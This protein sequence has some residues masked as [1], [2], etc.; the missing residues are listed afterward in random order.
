MPCCVMLCCEECTSVAGHFSQ[1]NIT[2]FA[3]KHRMHIRSR[4]GRGRGF[5]LTRVVTCIDI[6]VSDPSKTLQY[7]NNSPVGIATCYGLEGPGIEFRCGR[8]FPRPSRP[9]VVSTQPPTQWVPGLSR[10]KAAGSW[11]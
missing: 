6:Y 3:T 4:A 1:H 7:I 11:R 2:Q 8:D 5:S 9:A 10:G